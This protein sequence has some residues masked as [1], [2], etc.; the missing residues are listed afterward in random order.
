MTGSFRDSPSRTWLVV[1]RDEDVQLA[2]LHWRM[3]DA[4]GAEL[5]SGDGI[6]ADAP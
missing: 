1:L 3:L 2:D 4:S 6:E 5:R